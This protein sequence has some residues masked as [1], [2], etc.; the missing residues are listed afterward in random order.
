MNGFV[1]VQLAFKEMTAASTLMTV[2]LVSVLME[3][4]VW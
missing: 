2:I 1:S 4:L 3:L